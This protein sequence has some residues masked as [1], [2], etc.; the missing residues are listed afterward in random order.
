MLHLMVRRRA[1]RM[2][3][4]LGDDWQKSVAALSE[5]VHH[6]FPGDHPLGGNRRSRAAV[7]RWFQRLDRLFPGHDFEVQRVVSRGWPWS[8]WVAVQW[9]AELR[10]AVGEPYVNHGA[11]WLHLRWGKVVGLYAYLDSQRVAEACNVM[12][13]AGIAEAEAEPI[14]D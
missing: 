4:L 14:L 1:A 3:G 9:T 2:F 12:A 13:A 6:V 5:D 11:H 8:I 7:A 10:P